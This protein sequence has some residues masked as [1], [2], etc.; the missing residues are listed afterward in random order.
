MRRLHCNSMIMGQN[1][2]W[3]KLF[4]YLLDVG[5]LNALV[6]H[7]FTRESHMSIVEFKTCLV[8]AFMGDCLLPIQALGHAMRAE[9][10]NSVKPAIRRDNDNAYRYSK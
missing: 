6:L 5:T 8:K 9:G 7:N 2:W 10:Q 3:P 1:C 4:F